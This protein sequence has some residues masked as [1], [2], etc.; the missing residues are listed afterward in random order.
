MRFPTLIL[1]LS[2]PLLVGGL[3]GGLTAQNAPVDPTPRFDPADFTDVLVHGVDRD[4]VIELNQR[5]VDIQSVRGTEVLVYLSTAGIKDLG[6]AGY[7][8]TVLP[9]AGSRAARVGYHTFTEI[10][11]ALQAI[12]AAYPAICELHSAGLSNQGRELW[13]M[14]ISDNVSV[15]EDEPE[16]KYIS[17]MHGDEVV[18]M[19]LCIDLIELLASQYG[20]DPQITN[21]V[22]EVEIWIM[23]LMNPDGYVAGSRYNSTG[24]D[25]NR[26]FPDRVYD[27]VN[28]TAGRPRETRLVMDW[29]FAHE[30]VLSANFHGGAMVVNYP[31]DSDPNPYASYSTAPDD[32]LLIQ[33]S[34]TYSTLNSPMYNSYWFS[35]GITNGVAW[36]AIDGGMQD[37]NYVWLGCNEVTIELDDDKWP[38]F[39]RIAGLWNDNRASMLAYM[40]LCLTGVR[41]VVTDSVTGAPV[42]ATVRAVG[43]NHDVYTDPDVGDYHRMLLPGTYSVRVT[44]P[45]HIT[46]TISGVSVGSGVATVVD[47]ALVPDSFT[48]PAPDIKIDG[49][50]GPLSAPWYQPVHIT[51]SLAPGD[52]AGVPHDWWIK[53]TKGPITY[54]WSFPSTWS[55]TPTRC[56]AGPLVPL[57]NFTVAHTGLPVGT[58]TFTMVVDALDDVYQGTYADTIAITSY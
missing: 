24:H 54:W 42:D 21:L 46:Q 55:L 8:L 15:E 50:D 2:L 7:D 18:G 29:A 9:R 16:F 48:A 35:Q 1:F 31:Y 37:W 5:G 33:Q 38:N 23:P 41:G 34:L 51:A 13:F 30:S 56:Y 11:S 58:W 28:T 39:S 3:V 32:A 49:Q 12:E 53:A 4:G 45:G 25:L 57:N 40:D 17:S 14:K 43:I 6:D 19:E 26:S 27:P 47:V 44:A 22:N 10:T 52:L 36:Y 20:T